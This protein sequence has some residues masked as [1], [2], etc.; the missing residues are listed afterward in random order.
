MRGERAALPATLLLPWLAALAWAPAALGWTDTGHRV[1]AGIAWER[2]APE[3]RDAAVEL[4]RAA[5]EDRGIGRLEPDSGTDPG[6]AE[7]R[8]RQLFLEASTWPDRLKG[9]PHHRPQWHYVNHFWRVGPDG[10]SV[11]VEEL[12]PAPHNVVERLG[13]LSRTVADRSEPAA[14]RSVALAWVLHL[15]GDLHQPLHT[16]ARVTDHPEERRGDRGG[17]TFLLHP[18]GD[19]EPWNLHAWWDTA[20]DRNLPRR[21]EEGVE[22]YLER[23]VGVVAERTGGVPAGGPP[24]DFQ[25]WAREGVALA[26]GI[27]YAGLERGREPSPEYRDRVRETSLER[28]HRAGVRL[29]RL[30]EAN[31]GPAARCAGSGR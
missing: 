25:G 6:T 19:G 11:A 18:D 15:V 21:P 10:R 12:E 4:L 22:A 26:Q 8:R 1:V 16:S 5:P 14:E 24:D 20:L 31:L 9:T 27:V 23:L 3:T 2:M 7:D 28:L 17:N 29:A 30:L 13:V